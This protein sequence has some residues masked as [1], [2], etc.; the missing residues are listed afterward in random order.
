MLFRSLDQVQPESPMKDKRPVVLVTGAS[1]FVGRHL[2]PVLTREGGTV[3]RAVRR[4]PGNE[5]EVAIR[6][7]C[8]TTDW[9]NALRGA[10]AVVHLAARAHHP[11]EEHAVEL[12]R[13][14]NT[15]GTLHLARSAAKAGARQFIFVSTVLVH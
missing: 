3:R 7:I 15:E 4:L 1:G 6:S 14:L 11:H 8:P 2:A 9:Q 13:D 10:D 5:D 12:Y